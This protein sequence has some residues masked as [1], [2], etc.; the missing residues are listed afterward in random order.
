M[1]SLYI[2]KAAAVAAGSALLVGAALAALPAKDFYWAA[3]GNTAVQIVVGANAQVSDGI[4]AAKLAAVIGSKA[5]TSSGGS[6]TPDATGTVKLQIQGSS[7]TPTSGTYVDT[8]VTGTITDEGLGSG[9]TLAEAH[10]MA[11]G[12]ITFNG[13]EYDYKETVNV[14]PLVQL[15]YAE[16]KDYHGVYFKNTANKYIQYK[17][18]F[19]K[20][21]PTS[22]NKL[23]QTVELSFLGDTYVLNKLTTT[24]MHLVKGEKVSLGIGQSSDVTIGDKTYTVTLDSASL[25]ETTTPNTGYATISLKGGDL[26]SP[27]S[28]QLDTANTQDATTS[29]V[30]SYLQSVQKSYTPG[31]GGS[32]TLRIGGELLKLVNGDYFPGSDIWKVQ[33]VTSGT[34]MDYALV[35]LA[36]AYSTTDKVTQ[37]AGPKDYF[38]MSY[39]DTDSG[40]GDVEVDKITVKGAESS[41]RYYINELT[42]TDTYE[43]AYTVPMWD[44]SYYKTKAYLAHNATGAVAQLANFSND[45][46]LNYGYLPMRSGDYF[47]VKEQPFKIDSIYYKASDKA[48]S[49]IKL[50][51][52][53]YYFD[54]FATPAAN[55]DNNMTT[56]NATA[57]YLGY[58]SG[59]AANALITKS[60]A[61]STNQ[62]TATVDFAIAPGESMY[63]DFTSDNVAYIIGGTEGADDFVNSDYYTIAW[64]MPTW[65]YT[66]GGGTKT[67]NITSGAPG[68][69]NTNAIITPNVGL[70][71]ASVA[72]TITYVKTGDY[73][74]IKESNLY[75]QQDVDKSSEDRYKYQQNAWANFEA[76]DS[77]TIEMSV[78]KSNAKLRTTLIPGMTETTVAGASAFTVDT[79]KTFPYEV[80][81][82][83]TVTELGCAV[84]S[85]T[86]GVTFGTVNSNLVISDASSPTGNAIVIGGHYVNR[87]AVGMTEGTLTSAGTKMTELSGSTLYVAGYTAADTASAVD[88]LIASIKAL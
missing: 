6:V 27:V 49:Y 73:T 5:Y 78:F 41:T 71:P 31:Q 61:I 81:S 69:N 40:R 17:F 4:A 83:V 70:L 74:G 12:T 46:A 67:Y 48:A 60:V 53:A 50:N 44:D 16:D 15:T 62:G 8:A 54:S 18:D 11:K 47:F 29:G 84:E 35:Y 80:T 76:T 38:T 58:N 34:N 24:E 37:I 23:N 45:A 30:Y 1:K 82:D 13:L 22:D 19:V 75:V 68:V 77:S 79:T 10:G 59:T 32:A 43:N 20:N 72:S 55:G 86:T 2:K 28:I 65:N 66:F 7:S 21:F 57:F 39:A 52:Q 9:M 3:N 33:L 26:T 56:N 51:G 63:T 42:Y 36:K 88:A 87:L 14:D 25:D 85:V 64:A